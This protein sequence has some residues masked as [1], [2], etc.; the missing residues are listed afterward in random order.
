MQNLPERRVDDWLSGYIKYLHKNEAPENFKLWTAISVL[1]S[2]LQ[3]KCS[4]KLATDLVFYPNLYIIL[5]GPSGVRKGTAMNPGSSLITDAGIRQSAQA[6]TYQAL[7]RKLQSTNHNTV[8]ADGKL[9]FHS[10]LTIFSHEFTVFLGYG[11]RELMTAL[12]DWYDC[13]GRW[14]YETVARQEEV[15]IGVWV[16]LIGATTPDLIRSSLPADAVGSGLTSRIIFIYEGPD[17]MGIHPIPVESDA[18]KRLREG[19]LHDLEIIT[20]FSGEFIVEESFREKFVK[21]YTDTRLGA[22][23]F[24]DP[25][26]AGYINRRPNHIMKLSMI[27]SASRKHGPVMT[28]TE[29]DF[30]RALAVLHMAEGNMQRVYEGFGKSPIADTLQS[31]MAYIMMHKGRLI[32]SDELMHIFKGDLDFFTYERVVRTLEIMGAVDIVVSPGSMPSLRAK[33]RAIELPGS[34]NDVGS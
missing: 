15:I 33:D 13:K 19:L 7:I 16:N 30:H 14:T 25:R 24:Y 34:L 21:W 2:A 10:S 22:P 17:A 8:K 5:V 11:N 9:E 18:D 12:C 28:V 31:V 20:K 6:T 3:R 29:A 23:I 26:F 32:R 4:I 27:M 1:A